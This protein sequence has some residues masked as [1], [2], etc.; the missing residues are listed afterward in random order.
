[1]Q[2]RAEVFLSNAIKINIETHY[3]LSNWCWLSKEDER[4]ISFGTRWN[5]EWELKSV[6]KRR[7]GPLLTQNMGPEGEFPEP[8]YYS[9]DHGSRSCKSFFSADDY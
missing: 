3:C 8:Q 2:R 6:R 9:E 1:M 5:G 7:L 4:R